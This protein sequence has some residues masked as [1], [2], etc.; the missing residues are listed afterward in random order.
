MHQNPMVI[1]QPVAL[2]GQVSSVF[3]CS[4][5]AVIVPPALSGMKCARV[6]FVGYLHDP[7]VNLC[8]HYFS[9]L[10]SGATGCSTALASP[11]LLPSACHFAFLR[12]RRAS[13]RRFLAASGQKEF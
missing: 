12:A 1:E 7:T 10:S 6:Q 4:Y 13:L 8:V 3:I 5:F 11:G 9:F 2:H